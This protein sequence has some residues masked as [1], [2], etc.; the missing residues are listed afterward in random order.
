MAEHNTQ[1]LEKKEFETIIVDCPECYRAFKDFYPA[2]GYTIR[3]NVVHSSEYI[4]DLA[5]NGKIE[6][7]N[8][9]AKTLTYHDPCELARHS[10]PIVRTEYTTSDMYESP[11][12]VLN[13]IPGITLKE[14]R[15]T[16]DKT[17]CCGGGI[18]VRE[19]YPEFS[20]DIG[21]KVPSEALKVGAETLAVACPACKRQFSRVGEGEGNLEIYSIAELVAQSL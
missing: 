7:K 5:S 8:K 20:L 2:M 19:L 14:M 4:L 18:G 16:R 11:R 6:P 17:Y 9:I 10:T 15:W 3:A 1:A 21:K 13:K 12:E